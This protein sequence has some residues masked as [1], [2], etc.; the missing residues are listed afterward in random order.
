MEKFKNNICLVGKDIDIIRKDLNLFKDKNQEKIENNWN[1][2]SCDWK[3]IIQNIKKYNSDFSNELFSFTIIISLDKLN[4]EQKDKINKL[5]SDLED[6]LKNKTKN[7]NKISEFN[8]PF[9][10]LLLQNEAEITDL[11]KEFLQYNLIDKRNISFFITPLKKN[12]LFETNVNLIKR[13]LYRIY[14]YF[15]ELG[16]TIYNNKIK[17]YKE[18]Q[19]DFLPVNALVLGESQAGKST[20]INKILCEKRAKEGGG[21]ISVTKKLVTYHVDDVPLS[22]SDIEGFIGDKDKIKDIVEKIRTMQVNFEERE[23]HLIF[24]V[25]KY[26]A[27]PYFNKC[28]Y[29]IFKQLSKSNHQSQIIF[30]C[31]KSDEDQ[32]DQE[33][34]YYKIKRGFFTMIKEGMEK[35]TANQENKNENTLNYLYYCQKKEIYYEEVNHSISEDQFNKMDFYTRMAFKFQGKKVNEINEEIIDTIIKKDTNLIFVNLK[36]DKKHKNEFGMDKVTKRIINSLLSLKSI[37]LK[38]LKN[39]K[40]YNDE[41]LDDLSKSVD[42]LKFEPLNIERKLSGIKEI[43][44][45]YQELIDSIEKEENFKR[46]KILIEKLKNNLI[47]KMEGDLKFYKR[48]GYISGIIP[49]LDIPLQH[50]I[51][52]SAKKKI[53]YTFD[54]NLEDIDKKYSKMSEKESNNIKELKDKINDIPSDIIKTLCRFGTLALNLGAKLTFFAGVGVGIGFFVGGKVI[55]MDIEAFLDF[56]GKRFTYR[57][58]IG[59]SFKKIENYLKEHFIKSK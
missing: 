25:I 40:K 18:T 58:L 50:F 45:D 36:S 53:A 33:E 48:S 22:I 1:I 47:K 8:F 55:N 9:F 44:D 35:E 10:I 57:C 2:I 59:L 13:K 46:C 21:G 24:Y 31:T 16:D 37:N 11:T 5:F 32:E 34:A 38:I 28:E 7:S 51:K 20:F 39:G 19:E 6:N 52:E 17:L 4:N 43:N 26:G 30:I 29:D 27:E 15:Y 41:N 23:L 12:Y 54:D 56:Y 42:S 49:I 3:D 14:S